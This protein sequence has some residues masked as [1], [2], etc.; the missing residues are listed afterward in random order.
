MSLYDDF[1]VRGP[2]GN[3]QCLVTEVRLPWTGLER[4]L[5]REFDHRNII[6]QVA[7][8]FAFL[9]RQGIVHGGEFNSRLEHLQDVVLLTTHILSGPTVANI[10]LAAAQIDRFAE[11]DLSE[12]LGTDLSA[13]PV[14]TVDPSLAPDTVPA[15]M[16][17]AVSL[18]RF[19][20]ENDLL[21]SWGRHDLK[22]IDFG[23]CKSQVAGALITRGR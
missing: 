3:H 16:I 7:K 18:T 13:V 8:G 23:R 12:E 6:K 17:N 11:F 22:V 21:S 15:Y 19:L 1:I 5:W 9:H 2:N 14:M 4:I 10:G 20:S